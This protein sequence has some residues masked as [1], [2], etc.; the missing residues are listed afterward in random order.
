MDEEETDIVHDLQDNNRDPV[1]AGLIQGNM[2]NLNNGLENGMQINPFTEV[3]L[4]Q[5][6]FGKYNG[7]SGARK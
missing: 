2:D 6:S 7:G 4:K 5:Q 1:S 3:A